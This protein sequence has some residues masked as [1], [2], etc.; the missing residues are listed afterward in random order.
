MKISLRNLAVLLAGFALH[1][2]SPWAA[3][4]PVSPVG[5]WD[6]VMSGKRLGNAVI[7]FSNNYTLGGIELVRPVPPKGAAT[8]GNGRSSGETPGRGGSTTT[9]NNTSTSTN[10]A[11]TS[12]NTSFIGG[13]IIEGGW[14]LDPKGKVL[15][16]YRELSQNASDG[17]M[18][19]NGVSFRAVLNASGSR[20]TMQAY[21]QSGQTTLRGLRALDLP[22]IDR[23]FYGMGKKAG[24][25]YVDFFT[26]EP[27]AG[28]QN[29]YAITNG[30]ASASG[31][32]GAA[33]LSRQKQI[34]ILT[35]T[36]A[37]PAV[38]S[39]YV[40]PFKTNSLTGNL[41]GSDQTLNNIP[42]TVGPRF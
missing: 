6:F 2:S 22:D 39:V 35:I 14:T 31:L 24:Q 10:S 26:L 40:G 28:L 23:D 4:A 11:S 8:P 20:M 41:K 17:T 25:P 33:I 18:T 9:T 32:R 5:D 29:V 38:L 21:T 37:E 19:T 1:A 34:A 7:T 3:A 16:Y 13:A 30:Q 12:T 42:Y 15:G 36:E 27:L